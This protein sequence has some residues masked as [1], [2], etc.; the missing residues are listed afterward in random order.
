MGQRW[1]ITK[2]YQI[3]SS[4]RFGIEGTF[5]LLKNKFDLQ[6]RIMY[7]LVYQNQSFYILHYEY[8]ISSY[9]Y[10][11]PKGRVVVYEATVDKKSVFRDTTFQVHSIC[12]TI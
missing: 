11:V 1:S 6:Y 12:E 7:S 4:D 3:G 8:I 9:L 2:C 5:L 10:K